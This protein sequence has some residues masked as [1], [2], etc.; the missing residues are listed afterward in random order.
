MSQQIV[1]AEIEGY[2][3]AIYGTRTLRFAT[4]GFSTTGAPLGDPTL[5]SRFT[6]TRA[7]VSTRINGRGLV[8][9]VA[10]NIP[11]FNYDPL[12]LR[13]R[14]LLIEESRTNLLLNSLINGTSLATQTVV[15][16]ATAYT[17]SFYG[18]GTVTLSGSATGSLVG[19]GAYPVRS[20]LTFTPSAGS[21][22]L[23]VTGTVQFANLEAGSEAS[24]FIPTAAAS[25][26]R[27]VDAISMTGANF[28]PWYNSS[29]GTLFAEWEQ[30]TTPI[31]IPAGITDGTTGNRLTIVGGTSIGGRI[32]VGGVATDPAA[33]TGGAGI[34]RSVIGLK[35]GDSAQYTNGVLNSFIAPSGTPTVSRLELGG[36]P[37][38]SSAYVNG[39][40]RRVM[41]WPTRLTNTQLQRLTVGQLVPSG[42]S[43]DLD[44]LGGAES[45]YEA[46]IQVPPSVQ[47]ECFRGGRTFGQS[48]IGFGD[49]VLVNN[50]GGL[51]F[52]LNYSYSGR[53]ITIRLGTLQ[54]NGLTYTWTTIL[55]GSMEQVELSWQEVTVRVR[56]R[57]L[58]IAKPLQ[59]VRYA[60]GNALPAGLEGNDDDL[61]GKPKPLVYGRVFNISPPMVNTSRL[62]YQIH[63]GGQVVAVNGVYD[64]GALMTAG[65]AYSSQADMEA[66]AP[67]AGQ[68][69]VWNDTTLG[70]F[71]RLGTNAVGTITA[72]VTQG[73]SRTVGQLF[74]AIL[75]RAGIAA[76]DISSSDIAAL[77]AAVNYE[78]G[79]YAGVDE[80]YTPLQLLD[81]LCS[82][83][84]AWFGTDINGVFRI[85]LIALPVGAS[86]G[87]LTTLEIIK[88]ERIASRD[89]GVGIPAW[90]VK[91]GWQK[92]YTV[93][94]D[95]NTTVAAGRKAL[96]AE[97]YRR[98]EAS[99][100]AVRTA[101]L[102][103]PELEFDTVLA[104]K[105]NVSAEATR[106]LSIYKQRRDIY[107]VQVRVDA[108]LAPI[109]DLGNIITL[110]IN[111]FGMSAGKKFLIIGVKSNMRG[112]LFDL[113]L[114]G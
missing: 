77:D 73:A 85:G 8:E 59:Q 67:T 111:R 65:A 100:D 45:F 62:I 112:Y 1:V 23:T 24:S 90:K 91:L 22:T 31:A 47:R 68:Y 66:N 94:T 26:T 71:I 40:I 56:D 49:M 99:D 60:G 51:D 14:G 37:A 98:A 106:R 12:T 46:R 53:R 33:A 72:D 69:R 34:H 9:S 88:I 32:T 78:V 61:R 104:D 48:Q 54:P 105:A 19:A 15:V 79:V 21:L 103:S 42:M 35:S 28:T 97:K 27:S 55:V 80:D 30:G 43:L 107:Q 41:Y 93:Q 76:S 74:Q 82:S 16:A 64:R 92:V 29:E 95:L 25:V 84:G 11:R 57:Q 58:D 87:T 6:V 38:T 50:D 86:L 5:D 13:L 36:Q 110:Q 4:Q 39:H 3:P 114:W 10:A 109:L 52:M 7:G 101:N 81:E 108:Q 18:A 17:L 96:V 63:T 83:I 70:C 89:A 102:L 75:L 20:T 113:T 44:L 2:D